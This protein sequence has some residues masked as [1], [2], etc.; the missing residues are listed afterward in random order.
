MSEVIAIPPSEVLP[1]ASSILR[2]Q[3]MGPG[4]EVQ[5]RIMRMAEE[6]R[7]LFAS[8]VS[9]VGIMCEITAAEFESVY[10]GLGSNETP[11]PMEN[12]YPRAQDL[13]LSAVTVGEAV[14][15]KI[16]HLFDH[17]DFA[18]GSM[19]DAAASAGAEKAASVVE[20]FFQN[21]IAASGRFM[22]GN[23]VMGY[24]PGYCGWHLSA[25]RKLFDRL[26]PEKIG[27]KLRGSFLMEPIKSISNVLIHGP[28]EIHLFDCGYTFCKQC[29]S[30]TCRLRMETVQH[31]SSG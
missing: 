28:G 18:L 31:N 5:P 20:H 6:A 14:C 30:K 23:S 22:A 17:A 7:E 13:A 16:S 11:A 25:Q 29:R 3:G 9:P 10:F 12:I 24:S 1:D 26:K 19:L 2:A 21:R 4:V 15:R 27:I 8:L